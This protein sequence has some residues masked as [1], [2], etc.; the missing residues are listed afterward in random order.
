MTL[1]EARALLKD[2]PCVI[3]CT[4]TTTVDP[5]TA[6]FQ[7]DLETAEKLVAAAYPCSICKWS[8]TE[9]RVHPDSNYSIPRPMKMCSHPL[10]RRQWTNF[11]D[12]VCVG[13]EFCY[14][15]R[16]GGGYCGKAGLLWEKK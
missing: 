1:E 12:G 8:K 11:V 9:M 13:N 3:F 2:N 7:K 15:E 16:R 14:R 10:V 5:A 4:T 6:Q